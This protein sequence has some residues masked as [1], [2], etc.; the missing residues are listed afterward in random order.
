MLLL[1]NFSIEQSHLEWT[2]LVLRN[3]LHL[4]HWETGLPFFLTSKRGRSV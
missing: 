3:S 2:R 1:S 4:S